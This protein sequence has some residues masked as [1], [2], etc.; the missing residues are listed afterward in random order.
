[1]VSPTPPQ[2]RSRAVGRNGQPNTTH[3]KAERQDAA[4]RAAAPAVRVNPVPPAS[5]VTTQPLDD[6]TAFSP[7]KIVVKYGDT[8][9]SLSRR[10]RVDLMEL[11]ALNKL[12]SDRILAGQELLLP[13]PLG[14][15][16]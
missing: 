10:Y 14:D 15:A 2:V 5:L 7:A 11:R 16:G 9:W 13:P 3:E 6:P 8:L 4:R 12:V 1:M